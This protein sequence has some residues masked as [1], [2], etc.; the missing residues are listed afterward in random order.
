MAGSGLTAK[1]TMATLA[2]VAKKQ[3]ARQLE[4]LPFKKGTRE[5]LIDGFADGFRNALHHLTEM[6]V[7]E[8]VDT[9]PNAE[10]K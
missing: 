5:A 6:G 4:G 2:D 1:A 10:R 3:Y 9:T 7:I 8:V